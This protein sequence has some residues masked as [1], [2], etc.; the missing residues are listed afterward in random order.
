MAS[1]EHVVVVGGGKMGGDIGTVFAGAGW[2]VDIVEPSPAVRE[3]LPLRVAAALRSL[4][5]SVRLVHNVHVHESVETVR[6]PGTDLVVESVP[7]VLS[8]KQRVLAEVSRLAPKQ[9]IIT[10]NSSSLRLGEVV[11]HVDLKARTAGLHW[12]TPAHIAP[13]VEVVRGVRTSDR[14]IR[15]LNAW[16][17][18]LGK[19][20]INLNRDVPGM[21]V[22]RVQHAMMREAFNLI[23][24]GIVSPEDVDAAVRF[25]FGF[26]YVACGP[27]RQ[28][29]L[30]GLTIHLQSA[31]QIYPT[32]HNGPKPPRCLANRVKAGHAGI[33]A[34]K[35]FYEWNPRTRVADIARFDALMRRALALMDGDIE[36][37]K[38]RRRKKSSGRGSR[39]TPAR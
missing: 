13:L 21:L 4:R 34:G 28:R 9:A 20:A 1:K 3:R 24:R 16:L 14:T 10:T 36:L 32:L 37:E 35:G 5:R 7:E 19:L 33:Q 17:S 39:R 30:N 38:E 2:M 15:Q 6:W 11:A 22:N 12:L 26:R 31:A 23:D 18:E 29:D 8:V 27:V 25:G